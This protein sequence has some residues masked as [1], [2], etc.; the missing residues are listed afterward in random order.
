M[1]IPPGATSCR[2]YIYSCASTRTVLTMSI[3]T[4][5]WAYLYFVLYFWN[6]GRVSRAPAQPFAAEPPCSGEAGC[7][8]VPLQGLSSCGCYMGRNSAMHGRC[9][10]AGFC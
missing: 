1:A 4:M 10:Q 3:L 8:L 5:A 6:L 2:Q 9:R 7:M